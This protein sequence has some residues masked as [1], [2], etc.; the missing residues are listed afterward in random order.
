MAQTNSGV[1][2]SGLG[3]GCR[4]YLVDVATE[5]LQHGDQNLVLMFKIVQDDLDFL[6]RL[7]VD[8]KVVFGA[9]F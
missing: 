5:L 7:D 4:K 6:L 1:G 2:N 8:L 9:R 3:L